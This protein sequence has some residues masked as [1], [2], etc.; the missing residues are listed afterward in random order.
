MQLFVSLPANSL[1]LA[2]AASRAG[3]DYL[4]LHMNV[5]HRA[6]GT[7]F[8]GFAEEADTVR[9]IMRAVDCPVGL[10][11]GAGIQS[12]PSNHELEQLAT[13]G[14]HFLDFY[15]QHMPLRFLELPIRL[16]AAF[17]SFDGFVEPLYYQ[18]HFTWPPDSNQNRIWMAEASICKPED[19][20]QAFSF[21]D[22]RRLRI[23]QEYFD[24]P[25]L[26]PTQK[27]ITPDDARWLKRAGAGGLMIG[28][29]VTGVTAA[30][31]ADAT[32][33]YRNA[34]DSV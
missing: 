6:S 30:S 22:L 27:L 9:E 32:S 20:G 11:P 28:A 10:M 7:R 31:I 5:E 15:T 2:L 17:D 12:M 16:I 3:A 1:E 19:Y 13:D 8:G 33:A 25:L 23:M 21:H 26:V 4:K 14:L 24:A 18:T 29:I 34:I